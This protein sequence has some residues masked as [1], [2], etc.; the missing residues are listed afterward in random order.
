M[1]RTEHPCR[2]HSRLTISDITR[3]LRRNIFGDDAPVSAP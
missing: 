2:G 1:R 3:P